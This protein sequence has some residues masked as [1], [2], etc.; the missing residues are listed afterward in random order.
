MNEHSNSN[1]FK[2][3]LKWIGLILLVLIGVLLILGLFPASTSGMTSAPNPATSYDQ[4]VARYQEIEQEESGIVGDVSGSHLL[5]HGERTP[6]AYVLVHGVTNSPLQW[7]ELG[8]TLYDNGHNVLILRMPFHGLQSGQVSELKNLTGEDLREYADQAM[9][10]AAGLGDEVVV[11]GISGGAAVAAWMAVN[12][13][14]VDKALLLAPFF[15]IK[16]V[17]AF[18]GTFLMNAFSRLPNLDFDNPSEQRHEW[19]YRGES[20]RGVAAFLELGH[21]VV[22]AAGNGIVPS[23]E[24]MVLTTAVDDT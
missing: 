5:T 4:A 19:V 13:P 8:Q 11:V 24:I 10:I 16:S 7:L 15:G 20:S 2:Q 12:R 22:K 1:I 21:Q 3:I 9:D 6:R 23:A 18:A 17:P 14:E